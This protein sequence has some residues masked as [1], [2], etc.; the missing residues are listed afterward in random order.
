MKKVLF[1][2]YGGG[3][4]NVVVPIAKEIDENDIN[5]SILALTTAIP[6][7]KNTNLKYK[8]LSN[9]LPMLNN[10]QKIL[11]IGNKL[12]EEYHNPEAGFS[13]EETSAYLGCSMYDL[14]QKVGEKDALTKFYAEGR[15]AFCP[16]V[17]MQQILKIEQPDV[18]VTT[19]PYRMEKAAVI[20]AKKLGIKTVFIHDLHFVKQNNLYDIIDIHCVMNKFVKEQLISYGIDENKIF[21]TGQPAFD[22]LL[23]PMNKSR[24][25]I[26]KEFGLLPQKKTIVWIADN[27]KVLTKTYFN[28][29][30]KVIKKFKEYQFILKMHPGEENINIFENLCKENKENTILLHRCNNKEMIYIGDLFLVGLSTMGLEIAYL[31]KKLIVLDYDNLWEKRDGLLYKKSRYDYLGFGVLV[32]KIDELDK[33]ILDILD[34]YLEND[35]IINK[36]EKTYQITRN[37]SQNIINLL[38]IQISKF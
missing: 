20:E 2:T 38:K 17:I 7:L 1:V 36:T 30:A 10:S 26:Y 21:I 31:N 28:E 37:A 27:S 22:Y 4:V 33:M 5:Y 29:I 34:K 24:N 8:T 19:V 32:N 23:K 6:Y 16:T 11:N 25:G 9:Y 12:A 18:L 3:H 35:K 13:I 14:I 15:K